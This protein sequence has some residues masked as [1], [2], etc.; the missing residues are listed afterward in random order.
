MTL[1]EENIVQGDV[2]VATLPVAN[3]GTNV[4]WMVIGDGRNV[5]EFT[6]LVIKGDGSGLWE[7]GEVFNGLNRT[8]ELYKLRRPIVRQEQQVRT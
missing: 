1:V 4:A 6:I 7:D 8:Y 5:H 2:F 3:G